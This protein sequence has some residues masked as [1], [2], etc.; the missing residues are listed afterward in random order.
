MGG[1]FF[2]TQLYSQTNASVRLENQGPDCE[3]DTI[4]IYDPSL[5]GFDIFGVGR[6][7]AKLFEQKKS[8]CTQYK[9]VTI[10]VTLDMQSDNYLLCGHNNG[11]LI[12]LPIGT[13]TNALQ[14]K[15]FSNMT[16]AIGTVDME[17]RLSLISALVGSPPSA[18]KILIADN[19]AFTNYYAIEATSVVAGIA[20]FKGLPLYDK[21]FTFSAP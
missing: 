6:D 19:P 7:T 21:Y 1:V 5:Y 13:E 12:R 3:F 15:W 4:V 20:Y 14:R 16:G 17:L 11:S 9:A 18:V 2:T 10:E 8:T